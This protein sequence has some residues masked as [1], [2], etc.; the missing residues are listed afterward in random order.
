MLLKNWAIDSSI[1][2]SAPFDHKEKPC[3][4]ICL[5]KEPVWQLVKSLEI[6]F[7]Y[8]KLTKFISLI[9][10]AI[11]LSQFTPVQFFYTNSKHACE[12]WN[13]WKLSIRK[14]L[15]V[16]IIWIFSWKTF[17][18]VWMLRQAK[19]IVLSGKCIKI[20]FHIWFLSASIDVGIGMHY[21]QIACPHFRNRS[22]TANNIEHVRI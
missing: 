16:K 18:A 20:L 2:H 6:P 14:V 17:I 4:I 19:Q 1:G 15:S 10:S 22:I 12:A 13:R 11:K 5:W 3:Q 7:H 21:D 9:H 8:F